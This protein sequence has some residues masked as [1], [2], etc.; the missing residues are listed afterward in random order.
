MNKYYTYCYLREDGTPYYIG[1]G[2]G[3][4]IRNTQHNGIKVPPKERRLKL[5]EDLTQEDSIRYERY[6]ISI[7]GRLCDGSGILENISL[8]GKGCLGYKH[9]EEHKQYMS[10]L[11]PMKRPEVRVKFMKPLPDDVKQRI[12]KSHCKYLWTFTSPSG[13]VF[14]TTNGKDFCKK[15]ELDF[16]TISKVIRG[17]YEKHKGWSVRRVSPN[18]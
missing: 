7:F 17:K 12:S 15:H 16:S 14:E 10:V 18:P 5:K 9:T 3:Y 1:Q 8:G 11:N 4:R 2:C 6:Y 13:E